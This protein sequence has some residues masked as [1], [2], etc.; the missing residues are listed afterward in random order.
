MKSKFAVRKQFTRTVDT[1]GDWQ[2]I[3][4]SS[5]CS[6][7]SDR[8]LKISSSERHEEEIHGLQAVQSRF[9]QRADM[10]GDR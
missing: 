1:S 5:L 3:R 9:A 6:C 4:L 8:M 7:C 2:V 10:S